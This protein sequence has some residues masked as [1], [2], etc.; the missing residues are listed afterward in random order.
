[1]DSTHEDKK[2][3]SLSYG[4]FFFF[5]VGFGTYLQDTMV[6]IEVFM[7]EQVLS[8][9]QASLSLYINKP[10]VDGEVRDNGYI[11]HR[12]NLLRAHLDQ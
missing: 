5:N 9:P 2:G 3:P 6:K 7:V 10:T 12:G 8:M 4:C 11:Q 1:M